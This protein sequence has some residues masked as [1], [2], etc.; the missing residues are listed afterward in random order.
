MAPVYG[1]PYDF[2]QIEFIK[3]Q[4]SINQGNIVLYENYLFVNEKL[5]GLHVYDN[6]DQN[7]PLKIGFIRI[8]GNNTMTI[9]S[10]FLYADNSIHLLVIDIK[11][12]V[13]PKYVSFIENHFRDTYVQEQFPADYSGKFECAK[14]IKGIVIG[15]EKKE[16][17]NPKCFTNK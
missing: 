14:A 12:V 6:S 2:S 7:N 1:D 16:I 4:P 3:S 15:W 8:P 13:H 9:D 11:D 17:T 5:K 10:G